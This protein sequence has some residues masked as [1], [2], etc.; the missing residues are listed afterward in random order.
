MGVFHT[1]LLGLIEILL[2]LNRSIVSFVIKTSQIPGNYIDI[3][4]RD[5]IPS[6]AAGKKRS[7]RLSW[8]ILK[9]RAAS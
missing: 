8:G 1:T 4:K 5:M 6:P 3:R 2:G 9:R 7:P